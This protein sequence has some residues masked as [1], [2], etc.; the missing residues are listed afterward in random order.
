[1]R[2]RLDFIGYLFEGY[3]ML[4]LV[5]SWVFL[6]FEEEI[7]IFQGSVQYFVPNIK[8]CLAHLDK[9]VPFLLIRLN[10][11]KLISIFSSINTDV[12]LKLLLLLL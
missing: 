4:I 6:G 7:E 8:L 12:I 3:F 10:K 5:Y 11:D 2:G 9:I 1:M